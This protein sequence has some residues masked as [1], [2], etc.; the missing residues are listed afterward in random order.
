MALFNSASKDCSLIKLATAADSSAEASEVPYF[1]RVAQESSSAILV[2]R[3]EKLR[4][5][6]DQS[7][8]F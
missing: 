2:I 6:V 5:L 1:S 8:G 4:H 3:W 7:F